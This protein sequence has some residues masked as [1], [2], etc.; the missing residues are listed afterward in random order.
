MRFY[1]I[2]AG[3]LCIYLMAEA[4]IQ[5]RIVQEQE[6]NNSF[7]A[8]QVI[9]TSLTHSQGVVITPATI[10]PA[11]DRDYYRFRVSESGIYSLRVDTNRDTILTLYNSAGEQI[12]TNNDGGNPDIPNRMASGL[13][14]SLSAGEYLAEVRYLFWQGVCRYALRLFPGEQ[15]PDSDPTEPNDSRE[16]AVPLGSFTGGELV[17]EVGF[18]SY[19]G[20]DID[21]YTFKSAVSIAGL[22]IRTTTYVDTILRVTTPDGNVYENDDSNWDTLN[23]TASEVYIPLGPAGTYI[24]EVRTFGAWGGYYQL[25]IGAELPSQIILQDADTV[26]RLRNLMGA[27]DRVPTNN[28][29]WLYGGVDH[30]F[31]QGWWYRMEGIHTR[32]YVPSTLNMIAQD[33][34]N[35]VFLVYPEPDGL[36]L[37]FS[38]E[39]HAL[40]AGGATLT[41]SVLAY[42]LRNSPVTL[43]LFHYFDLDVGGAFTNQAEWRNGRIWVL[44][45]GNH[46]GYITPLTPFTH[47]EVT[48]YPQTLNRLTDST[49][50]TL[51]DG[52]LPFEGDFTGAFQWRALLSS[53]QGTGIRVHYAL[54]TESPPL[55]GDVNRDGC[56]DDSDL[57][58]VLFAFGTMGIFLPE[59]V[60]LNGVVDDG[61]L[62]IVLF[63]FGTGC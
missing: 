48:P 23:G 14:L 56:I 16:D 30:L 50:T 6:P 32:E 57:L 45:A 11:G 20:S 51:M 59:D 4:Q 60:D 63:N 61:D 40:T 35:R 41:C 19:G 38:Y 13:T 7:D 17:S 55:Q 33:Q 12:A 46:Y 27:R 47:W 44:G 24:L 31:Q 28:A 53:S 29:D 15:A 37:F 10:H 58:T 54:D 34:P 1:S 22:R 3:T 21:M 62:L 5:L 42:N 18:S 52:T 2:L 26:F 9:A 8:P 25:Q 39:L 43:H 36:L 49:A